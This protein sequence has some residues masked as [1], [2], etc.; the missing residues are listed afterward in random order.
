MCN[1]EVNKLY[2]E[3]NLDGGGG[4]GGTNGVNGGDEA[5]NMFTPK[6]MNERVRKISRFMEGMLEK[7]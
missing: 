5:Y 1:G 3:C 2:T 6:K 4:G 7:V